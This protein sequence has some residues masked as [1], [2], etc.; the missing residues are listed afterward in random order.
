ML[1]AILFPLLVG[2]RS[3]GRTAPLWRGHIGSQWTIA[4]SLILLSDL[5]L[6]I[7]LIGVPQ[8]SQILF[9]TAYTANGPRILRTLTAEGLFLVLCVLGNIRAK[10]RYPKR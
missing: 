5:L 8:D 10:I 9:H 3:F 7:Y 2:K 6:G 1:L 4:I